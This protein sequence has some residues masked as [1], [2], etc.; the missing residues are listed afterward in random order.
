MKDK[1]KSNRE[2]YAKNREKILIKLK[3]WRKANRK[4]LSERQRLWCEKNR[5]KVNAYHNQWCKEHRERHNEY[6][7]NWYH[8]SPE[9]TARIRAYMKEWRKVNKR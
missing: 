3:A 2:Y 1:N 5:E 9:T 7:R 6:R 4:L 8:S